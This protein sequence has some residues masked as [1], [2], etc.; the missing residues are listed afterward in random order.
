MY[1]TFARILRVNP[2]TVFSNKLVIARNSADAVSAVKFGNMNVTATGNTLEL[3][4][5]STVYTSFGPLGKINKY[6]NV[7]HTDGKIPIGHTANGTLE[8]GNITGSQGLTV[9]NNAGAIAL[10][11]PKQIMVNGTNNLQ[12]AASATIYLSWNNNIQSGASSAT[13]VNIPLAITI[14]KATAFTSTGQDASGSLVIE[15]YKNNAATG[16]IITI[17]AGSAAGKYSTTGSVSVSADDD[18]CWQ[19]VNKVFS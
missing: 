10:T 1:T 17:A 19:I 15:L 5:G 4:N 12:L 16:F 3:F 13:R 6:K 8:L 14:T 11:S 9:T 2:R 18:L 7:V